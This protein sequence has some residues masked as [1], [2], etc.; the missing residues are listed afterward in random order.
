MRRQT[1]AINVKKLNVQ[2]K[3]DA[4]TLKRS[5]SVN[6]PEPVQAEPSI[7]SV[8]QVNLIEKTQ[9]VMTPRIF[10]VIGA[11]LVGF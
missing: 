7:D 9:Q 10:C 2:S 5:N 6:N 11:N 1:S 3:D 4:K 8:R